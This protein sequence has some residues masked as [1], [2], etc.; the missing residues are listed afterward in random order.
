MHVKRK[1]S[2]ESEVAQEVS[3]KLIK[4]ENDNIVEPFEIIS[5]NFDNNENGSSY[6]DESLD[7]SPNPETSNSQEKS[8]LKWKPIHISE[9]TIK[10]PGYKY[11]FFTVWQ[12]TNHTTISCS[13]CHGV[14]K[15]N[16]NNSNKKISSLRYKSD[17]Y[18]YGD[19]ACPGGVPH[20][21]EQIDEKGNGKEDLI[22]TMQSIQSLMEPSVKYEYVP[23]KKLPSMPNIECELRNI[24]ELD[25]SLFSETVPKSPYTPLENSIDESLHPDKNVE[26]EKFN[27]ADGVVKF[28]GISSEMDVT[29]MFNTCDNSNSITFQ[30][31]QKKEYQVEFV[32]F[33]SQVKVSNKINSNIVKENLWEKADWDQ[34]LWAVRGRCASFL[35][36]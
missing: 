35:K 12:A 31:K 6:F 9:K 32:D 4:E 22:G 11:H 3:S 23:R 28:V 1:A 10:I 17:G 29:F 14:R 15:R 26:S 7:N 16:K 33:G 21:C 18:V 2:G 19:P 36:N 20:L 27:L 8:E 13:A 30:S 34:F 25:P 5:E 24:K